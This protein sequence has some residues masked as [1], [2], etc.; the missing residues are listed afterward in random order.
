[1]IGLDIAGD[2]VEE[3]RRIAPRARIGGEEAQIGVDACGDRVIIA[4]PEMAI[5]AIAL[6]FAAHDHRNL[7][8][9]L[10]LD[11]AIDDLHP[12]TLELVRPDRKSTRLNSSHQCASR[13]PS[14][15]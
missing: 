6:P 12:R 7:G 13:M 11:E 15:A 9:G 8:M 14:S 2:I 1:M 10:P 3:L 5:G 4:G